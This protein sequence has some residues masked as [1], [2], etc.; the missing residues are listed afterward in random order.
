MRGVLVAGLLAAAPAAFAN[1][2]PI[3]SARSG[4]IEV[5]FGGYRPLVDRTRG[6]AEGARPYA[7]T[8]GNRAMIIAELEYDHMLFQE[9]GSLGVGAG[10]G[11][12]ELYAKA[13]VVG[14]GE[15]AA[16][17]TSLKVVPMRLLAV[18]RFD[19]G[20]LHHNIPFTP[21]VKAG[22]VY[23][24][25]WASTGADL[26]RASG[27]QWGYVVSAGVGFMLDFLDPRTQ[28]DFDSELGVNH[29]YLFAE[30]TFEEVN[31]FG[32][33]GL[34]LSSRRFSVGLAFDF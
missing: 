20:A 3:E 9:L 1:A 30:Y 29:T 21:F 17:S 25:F 13:T 22:L 27:G 31:D 34:D 8:F 4:V 28:R 6:L 14:T 32:Q 19:Y 11:Y 15:P 18:Y 10:I 2:P 16:E 24:P 7:T 23:T 5:K 33:G 26:E 12:A